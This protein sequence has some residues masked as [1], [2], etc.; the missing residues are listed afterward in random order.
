MNK[1]IKVFG[2]ANAIA[3]SI[4]FLVDMIVI[5]NGYRIFHYTPYGEWVVELPMAFVGLIVLIVMLIE[6]DWK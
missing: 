4:L 5:S 6:D 1:W 3:C 2:Y